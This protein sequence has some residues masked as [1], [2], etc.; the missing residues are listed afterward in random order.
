VLICSTQCDCNFADLT[1][2]RSG[3]GGAVIVIG[4]GETS[5]VCRL[6]VYKCL[7]GRDTKIR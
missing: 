6:E 7:H 4:N 5:Q 3:N 1:V 2:G